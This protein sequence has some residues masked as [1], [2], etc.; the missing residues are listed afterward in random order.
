MARPALVAL[1]LLTCL[2]LLNYLDRYILPGAQPLIQGEFKVSDERMGALTTALFITYMLTAPF[3]GWLGDRFRRKPLIVAGVVLWSLAT[4]VTFWVH[5][6]WSL[7]FRHALVGVGEATFGIFAPAVLSDFFPARDR[8][9]V[10]SFFYLAIPVGAA[11]GY[12]VGG[13]LGERFGWR[14]P[15]LVAAVPGLLIAVLYAIFAT[16]PQRGGADEREAAAFVSQTKPEREW[17][18]P[19][20][21]TLTELFVQFLRRSGLWELFTNP[22]FLTATLG[23]AMMV[24]ALGGISTWMPTFL[25]RFAGMSVSKA[26]FLLGAMTAGN[27][28]VATALGGW[29]AQR[30]LRTNHRALYLLSA[31][32]MFLALPLAAVTFFGPA[33]WTVAALAAAQFCLFLNTGPLNAAI[34]NSVSSGVRSSAIALNLFL[35]HALGDTFSPQIIGAISGMAHSNLRIGLGLTLVTLIVSG[36]LLFAG[37]RFAPALEER[38][39]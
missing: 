25:N 11:M 14:T 27:G 6:Y 39:S 15:F 19:R 9:R 20:P 17:K 10:L 23:M 34:C 33:Q 1:G 30:W 18:K 26:A 7:Y 8:N 12:L 22:G 37:A 28:I 32:S 31:W 35:I 29:L 16:E 36:V 4:L 2:N 21:L 5:D 13:Q 3:T 38:L 24:F